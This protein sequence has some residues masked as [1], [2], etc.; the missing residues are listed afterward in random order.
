MYTATLPCA[1]RSAN[2]EFIRALKGSGTIGHAKVHN[3]RLI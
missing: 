1:I 3:F 2:T